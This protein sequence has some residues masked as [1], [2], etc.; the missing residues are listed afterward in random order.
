ME[1]A[2]SSSGIDILYIGNPLLDIS[3]DDDAEGTILAKYKLE[4]G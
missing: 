4:A 1:V 2:G 3:I